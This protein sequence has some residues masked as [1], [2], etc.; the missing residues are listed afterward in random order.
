MS[1]QILLEDESKNDKALNLYCNSLETNDLKINNLT[2]SNIDC[3]TLSVDMILTDFKFQIATGSTINT[4][5]LN[6]K[7]GTNTILKYKTPDLGI[8][9]DVLA[10]DGKGNVFW[11]SNPSPPPSGILYNGT[12]PATTNRI[13]KISNPTGT[14]ANESA[15]LENITDI[16]LTSNVPFKTVKT[17]FTEDQEFITK[18]YVDDLPIQNPFNQSLNTTDN[19]NFNS[20]QTG[21]TYI[22][23]L[24]IISNKYVKNGGTNLEYLMADGSISTVS[25]IGSNIYYYQFDTSIVAPPPIQNGHI[26]FNTTTYNLVSNVYISHLTNG[27]IT[28]IDPFFPTIQPTNILYIQDRDDSTKW[29]KFNVVST[30]I[31]PNNFINI[32]VSFLSAP[33]GFTLFNNNHSIY[34]SIFSTNTVPV[35]TIDNIGTNSIISSNISPTFT[36]KGLAISGVGLSILPTINNLVLENTLPATLINL[37]SSGIGESLISNNTN[38]NFSIKSLSAG[39]GISISSTST[40]LTLTNDLPFT[41]SNSSDLS[42]VLTKTQ[43]LLSSVGSS[44]FTGSVSAGSYITSPST[45]NIL[46]GNGSTISQY[47]LSNV[48]TNS[49]INTGSGSD[50]KTKGLIAGSNITISSTA[51]DITINSSGGSSSSNYWDFIPM[52]IGQRLA[53]VTTN[54]YF[55]MGIV[56]TDITI[57][58][59][60]FFLPDVVSSS[61]VIR[62]ALYKGQLTGANNSSLQAQSVSNIPTNASGIQTMTFTAELGKSLNFNTGDYFWLGFNGLINLTAFF[63]T[64]NADLDN[65]FS[66]GLNYN[67]GFPAFITTA[68]S[69]VT[70]NIHICGLF[71]T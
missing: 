47:T 16:N 31:T 5:N 53:T 7:T 44:V 58:T 46:L 22:D 48:G 50:F 34:F 12:L 11:T 60:R 14:T 33:I 19:V 59:I 40:D 55:V 63:S 6:V 64:N 42:S 20:V 51:T 26:Q 21:M 45:T 49:L 8:L 68:L 36:L 29:I 38:P 69:R 3:D 41:S 24:G 13:L 23:N 18:K 30:A 52:S 17:I 56:P 67:S 27:T 1:I 9:G 70:T 66:V 62:F 35:I 54:S 65:C 28:D 61:T 43:N 25:S 57:N 15:I 2:V 37:S 32:S 39:S 71:N 4:D 10:T